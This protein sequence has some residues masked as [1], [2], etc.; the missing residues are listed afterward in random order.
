MAHSLVCQLPS[1]QERSSKETMII[2]SLNLNIYSSLSKT[3]QIMSRYRPIAPKP[4]PSIHHHPTTF[5]S[6]SPPPQKAQRPRPFLRNLS[7]SLHT[8]PARGC[9]KRT[10]KAGFSPC[11]SNTSR[12]SL[13]DFSSSNP[14]AAS[15]STSPLARNALVSPSMRQG[16]TRVLPRVTVSMAG[17]HG[18]LEKPTSASANLVT[19]PL[20]PLPS[21]PA[22][23]GALIRSLPA[24]N[25]Y[26]QFDDVEVLDLN[27]PTTES[28]QE[29]HL[30][31]KLQAPLLCCKVIAPQPVRPIGSS[32]SVRWINEDSSSTSTACAMPLHALRRPEEV[33]E[34]VESE[35][36]PAVV[37]DSNN[38]VRLAN[39]AYKEMVGQPE[40]SWLDATYAS[41]RGGACKRISGDVMLNLSDAAVP[42][43]CNGFS[44]EVRIEW[45]N[46]GKK[47][48]ICA[49]CDVI[50]LSCVSKDYLFSWRFHTKEASKTDFHA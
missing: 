22:S 41:L 20:L 40:C 45:G 13:L 14:H 47:S 3:D 21:T 28:P 16:F 44:C 48:Y 8:N 50:R 23:P 29:D 1:D 7:R 32:I 49:P 10:S 37:S 46:D 12:T 43:S 31:Q 30:L 39:S 4:Q 33:E 35:V 9:R 36:L 11:S 5:D 34:E 27:S 38:R 19:L 17:F 26:S 25:Y 24:A 15:S 6:T 18:V 2:N 42:P